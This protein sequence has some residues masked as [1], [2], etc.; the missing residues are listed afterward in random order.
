[1]GLSQGQLATYL[2]V[3]RTTVIR[4]ETGQGR[5]DLAQEQELLDLASCS[6]E[7]LAEMLCEGMSED[8][9]KPV[10]IGKDGGGYRPSTALAKGRAAIRKLG[11]EIPEI[12]ARTLDNQVHTT[13]LIGLAFERSCSDLEQLAD[14]CL[15]GEEQDP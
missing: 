6:S 7:Q 12:V 11:G 15:E 4:W 1:A 5:P 9:G 13:Q 14:R 3:H 2:E 10:R 8:L